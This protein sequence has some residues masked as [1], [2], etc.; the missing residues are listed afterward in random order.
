MG[1]GRRKALGRVQ[2]NSRHNAFRDSE[3]G[4]CMYSR[5]MWDRLTEAQRA[6]PLSQEYSFVCR[7][8]LRVPVC[9]ALSQSRP[10]VFTDIA[11]RITTKLG[12]DKEQ[13]FLGLPDPTL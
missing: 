8:S 9:W 10:F 7:G 5:Y 3:G 2:R 13:G 4:G 12:G 6:L 1:I 11:L